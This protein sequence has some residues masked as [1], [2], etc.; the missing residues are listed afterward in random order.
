MRIDHLGR[1]QLGSVSPLVAGEAGFKLSAFYVLPDIIPGTGSYVLS[2]Q[3]G[4]VKT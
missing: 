3:K 2:L 1:S 4:K